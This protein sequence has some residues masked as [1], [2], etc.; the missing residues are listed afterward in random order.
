MAKIAPSILSPE[1]FFKNSIYL[2]VRLRERFVNP[3]ILKNPPVYKIK[4]KIWLKM[5]KNDKKQLIFNVFLIIFGGICAIYDFVLIA[6]APGTFLDNLFSFSH[7]WLAAGVYLIFAG[8]Y[9]IKNGHSFWSKLNKTVRI[10][11]ICLLILG[12]GIS[13]VNLCYIL[14]PE[15]VDINE[16]SE[17]VILLGGGIDKY[18]RLPDSVQRRVEKTKEYMQLHPETVCVVTGGTLHWLPYAEAPE[19]KRQLV[20]A[21]I[22]EN[23]VLVEDQAL[24]T[25]QNFQLSCKMLSDFN[26]V[27]QKEILK[28]KIVVIT[29]HF[30]MRRALRLAHRMGF[31]NI[32][33]VCSSIPAIKVPHAYI[34]EICAYIKLNLRILLTGKPKVIE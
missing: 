25:I 4:D 10:V 32:K 15:T 29:S 17:Y 9:R 20:A 31:S 3:R 21:G 11:I 6:L 1:F 2:R 19:I 34:R 16:S 8:I 13:I 28:S 12:G 23:R 30:H 22:N 14:T 7:I 18:G 26:N 5:M 33:G 27:T 24:D